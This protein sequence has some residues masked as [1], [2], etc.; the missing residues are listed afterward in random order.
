MGD[1]ESVDSSHAEMSFCD[2]E[3]AIEDLLDEMRE[4]RYTTRQA[5]IEKMIQLFQKHYCLADI[6]DYQETILAALLESTKKGIRKEA[7]L[8]LKCISVLLIIIGEDRDDIY[9]FMVE[10]LT[11]LCDSTEPSIAAEAINALAMLAFVCSTDQENCVPVLEMCSAKFV[12]GGL[13]PCLEASCISNWALLASTLPDAYLATES[14]PEYCA[15]LCGMLDSID[16]DVRVAAGK[17]L[18]M[19]HEAT[20]SDDAPEADVGAELYAVIESL[21][22]MAT[23]NSRYKSKKEQVD[24]RKTFRHI[25]KSLETGEPPV[26]VMKIA[27]TTLEFEGWAQIVQL[28]SFR[29]ALGGGMLTHM[30]ENPLL[31]EILDFELDIE[32]TK[33]MSKIEKRLYMSSNSEESKW[34][35]QDLSMKRKART[36]AKFSFMNEDE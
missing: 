17:C 2:I 22:D 18:A 26:E 1:D 12:G 6:E 3:G 29:Q 35:T 8:A 28:A 16:L 34:R 31:G 19:L 21:R 11:N 30:R 7:V 4:K 20:M 14:F 25:L 9:K 5:A 15:P 23:E 27:G 13:H 24:Q 36:N 33:R 32:P 10:P